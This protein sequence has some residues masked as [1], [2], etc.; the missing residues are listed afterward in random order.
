MI[1][2]SRSN[3][4]NL[5]VFGTPAE[6]G[7]QWALDP[8]FEAGWLTITTSYRYDYEINPSINVLTAISGGIDSASG[9]WTGVPLIGFTA[10]AADVGSAQVGET[11][12]LIRSVNRN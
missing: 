10:M 7:F 11:V 2:V 12:E 1:S 4:T 8:G 6:N 9:T 5:S 3:G